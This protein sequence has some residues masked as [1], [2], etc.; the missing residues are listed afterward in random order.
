MQKHFSILYTMSEGMGNNEMNIY[1]AQSNKLTTLLENKYIIVGVLLVL[2][3]NV[4]VVDILFFSSRKTEDIKNTSVISALCPQSCLNQFS[5]I[6][7]TL[8]IPK[9]TSSASASTTPSPVLPTNTPTP[10][11]TPIPSISPSAT[12][13]PQSREY[14][15]PLGQGNGSYTDW[16]VVPGI[17]A[18][19]NVTSYGKIEKVYFEA[20]VRIP[21]GN[22]TVY[23]R[24]YNA[25]SSQNIT[26]SDVTLSSGTTTLL[27][28]PAISLTDTKDENLYQVQ[29][30]TQ[31]GAT[32]Y[33]EQ[34]RLR[35]VTR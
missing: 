11:A 9:N 16:T 13:T 23:V 28:S 25:S 1:S 24:L 21:N 12:P 7:A 5:Q 35:I 2:V 19:I 27:T 32:T 8:Q 20:A 17:G 31:L 15:I 30:K 29:L 3:I 34:A 6:T 4:I 14:F 33:I 10:T 26:N 18:K 22:Q